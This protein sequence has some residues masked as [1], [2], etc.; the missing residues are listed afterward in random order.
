MIGETINNW[1]ILEEIIIKNKPKKY[2][3][4]CKCGK[5]SQKRKEDIFKYKKCSDCYKKGQQ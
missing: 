5:E 2:K 1:K 3:C 4:I